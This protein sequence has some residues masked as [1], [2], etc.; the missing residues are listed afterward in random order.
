MHA[1]GCQFG[2]SG[3]GRGP[4]SVDSLSSLAFAY[5]KFD[6]DLIRNLTL[7]RDQRASVTAMIERA[8]LRGFQVNVSK[9]VDPCAVE[10]VVTV[11]IDREVEGEK[12]LQLMVQADGSIHRQG[13]GTPSG[14]TCYLHTGRSEESLLHKV[15]SGMHPDL[16]AAGGVMVLK[17]I[18]GTLCK[19]TIQFAY[20]DGG[21]NAF[22]VWYGSASAEPHPAIMAFVRNAIEQTNKWY[23]S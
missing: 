16:L 10:D 1:M 14:V 9:V 17:P 15:L 22:E 3:I 8:H 5:V 4:V 20:R 23:V 19:L 13:D 7:D 2:L 11:R 18:A 21:G 12:V 6:G